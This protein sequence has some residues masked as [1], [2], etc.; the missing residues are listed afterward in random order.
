[1]IKLLVNLKKVL[2]KALEIAVIILVAVLV[3]DV[4]WGVFS[5]YV[6]DAQSRWTEELATMLLIWV[7]LL[8]AAVAFAAKAHLGVDYFVAK[9]DPSVQR[10]I[11]GFVQILVFLF[12]AFVLIHGGN[13]LVSKTLAAGQLSPAMG[14]K[15]GYMYLAVPISGV[16]ICLL[17]IEQFVELILSQKSEKGEV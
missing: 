2:V 11:E 4:L 9:F 1:M 10:L 5:R 15:V 16:F 7:S 6:L 14:L 13:I 8:G 17:C 12:S 3:L